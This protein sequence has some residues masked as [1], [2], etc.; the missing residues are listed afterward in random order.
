MS[1]GE[2]LARRAFLPPLPD[3]YADERPGYSQPD[4]VDPSGYSAGDLRGPRGDGEVSD[5][6]APRLS[7]VVG[8][9]SDATYGDD[10][11]RPVP[12]GA[13]GEAG[14][15]WTSD[16][17]RGLSGQHAFPA[18]GV[19]RVSAAES[20]LGGGP[21]IAAQHAWRPVPDVYGRVGAEGGGAQRAPRLAAAPLEYTADRDTLPPS[22]SAVYTD[23]YGPRLRERGEDP[24]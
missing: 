17:S 19:G 6:S 1:L 12:G 15:A 16:E 13:L 23:V 10:T 8:R 21:G 3:P 4:A 24:G 14:A 2:K 18:S 7:P 5:V 9:L 20:E 11:V 22:D